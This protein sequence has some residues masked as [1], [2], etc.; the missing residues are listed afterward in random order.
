VTF[1]T[2]PADPVAG[3]TAMGCDWRAASP[4]PAGVS[5]HR[6]YRCAPPHTLKDQP[7]VRLESGTEPAELSKTLGNRGAV[8]N[9]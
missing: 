7:P 3:R 4:R 1:G 8:W 9:R 5:P 2:R 6:N